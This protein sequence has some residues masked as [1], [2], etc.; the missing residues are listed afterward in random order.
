[1]NSGSNEIGEASGRN[2]RERLRS[3]L[4]ELSRL[5]DSWAENLSAHYFAHA[6]TVA[7]SIGG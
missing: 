4:R 7:I 5:L 6:R 2:E 3:A 1:L